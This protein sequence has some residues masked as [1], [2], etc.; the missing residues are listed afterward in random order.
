MNINL[1]LGC[2][3]KTGIDFDF[4]LKFESELAS[5]ISVCELK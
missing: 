4:E 3:I 2:E 1:D 5:E